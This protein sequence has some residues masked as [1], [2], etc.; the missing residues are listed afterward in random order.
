MDLD[1]S[2]N[3]GGGFYPLLQTPAPKDLPFRP[4]GQEVARMP[5]GPQNFYVDQIDNGQARLLDKQGAAHM[6]P[7]KDYYRESM[8]TDGSKP[9]DD[10]EGLALRSRLSAGDTGGR[11]DLSMPPPVVPLAPGSPGPPIPPAADSMIGQKKTSS[12]TKRRR[13]P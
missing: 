7:A 12:Q 1:T 2:K 8:M 13:I 9:E 4:P 6:E 3:V 5:P 11:I 10:K